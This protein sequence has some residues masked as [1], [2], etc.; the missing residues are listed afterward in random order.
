MG[1]YCHA[2]CDQGS[3]PVIPESKIPKISKYG[4]SVNDFVPMNWRLVDKMEADFNGD[5]LKDIALSIVENNPKNLIKNECGFGGEKEFDSNPY[6]I[7]VALRQKNARY[8][9]TAKD[10]SIIPRLDNP[11]LEQPYSSLDAKK[12]ILHIAYH[13]FQSMGTW[14]TS[15]YTSLFRFQQGCM[16]LIGHEY[17]SLHRASLEENTV[18]TNFLT[19]KYVSSQY[20]PETNKRSEE[21]HNLKKN[22]KYCLGSG[23][24]PETFE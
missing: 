21:W 10:F 12:G 2:E 5:K 17:N 23:N 22:P 14:T 3:E 8:L 16:R 15:T 9:L 13:Y 7:V 19:G 1:V 6:A 11:I 24:I 20:N 18:S 4:D